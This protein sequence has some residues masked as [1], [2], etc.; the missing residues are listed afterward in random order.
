MTAG[1]T[2][3]TISQR[4]G[5]AIACTIHSITPVLRTS[6]FRQPPV[7]TTSSP[8][9]VDCAFDGPCAKCLFKLHARVNSLSIKSKNSHTCTITARSWRIWSSWLSPP[10]QPIVGCGAGRLQAPKAP[11]P[12]APARRRIARR[13]SGEGPCR[14]RCSTTSLKSRGPPTAGLGSRRVAVVA[15]RQVSRA[16]PLLCACRGRCGASGARG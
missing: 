14:L 11:V 15:S 2:A 12:A 4:R 10:A 5:A 7:G 8:Q 3:N 16:A 13:A 1:E 9:V 6:L